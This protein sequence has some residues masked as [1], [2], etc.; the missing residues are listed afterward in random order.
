MTRT[1]TLL[2]AIALQLAV[3]TPATAQD[4]EDPAITAAKAEKARLD[5]ETARYVAAKARSDAEAAA[6][7]ARLG[8]LATYQTPGAVEVGANSGRLEA[9]LLAS[10][11]TSRSAA[12]IASR[13][14]TRLATPGATGCG[15]RAA[16]G[17]CPATG[18]ETL[19]VFPEGSAP[20]FDAYDTFRAQLLSIELQ[21]KPLIPVDGQP[22]TTSTIA[23]PAAAAALS[24]VGN[25]LRS[26]YKLSGVEVTQSDALLVRTFIEEARAAC[27]DRRI[28]APSMLPPRID[29]DGNPAL[30]RLRE[31]AALRDKVATRAGALRQHV[32]K[33]PADKAAVDPVIA[34]LDQAV[35]RFDTFATRVGTPDDKGVV[36]L[37][38]VARQAQLD[39][40]IKDTTMMLVLKAELAGGS[41]YAKKNFWTFLGEMPFSVSGGSLISYTLVQGRSSEFV[42]AGV[43]RQTEPFMKI[44]AATRRFATQ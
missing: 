7:Q 40:T 26:D 16:D 1:G 18:T 32:A 19:L 4:A 9:T 43:L 12:K 36:P 17:A 25:L 42:D 30:V 3:A 8:P 41:A 34:V 22:L 5:A 38:V 23:L 15:A 2:M 35:A 13:L 33:T 20:T 29:I 21:L 11:A 27:L 28:T 44:H 10:A 14:C 37:A 6:A 31:V 24:A 39:G